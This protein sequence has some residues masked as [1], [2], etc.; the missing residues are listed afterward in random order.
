MT[1]GD[2]SAQFAEMFEWIRIIDA[3]KFGAS[4]KGVAGKTIKLVAYRLALFGDPD[5]SRVRPGPARI[6]AV[7]EVDYKTAK[8]VYALLREWGFLLKVSGARGP[9]AGGKH[10]GDEYRLTVPP[11]LLERFH[12]RSPDELRREV[13]EIQAANRRG[14]PRKQA[15]EPVDNPSQEP[16]LRGTDAPVTQGVDAGA[17]TGVTGNSSPGNPELRGTGG[18]SYGELESAIPTSDLPPTSTDHDH[19]LGRDSL[20]STDPVDEDQNFGD[21]EPPKIGALLGAFASH[22]SS[23]CGL[24]LCNGGVLKI[25]INTRPCPKCHPAKSEGSSA[26]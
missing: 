16:E 19:P 11:D 21:D 26:A 23:P 2:D 25:G 1:A 8:R 3:I 9:A 22:P 10:I 24:P 7:C 14:A 5:G 12:H 6:A 13:D 20:P 4:V 15:P 17:G 18:C